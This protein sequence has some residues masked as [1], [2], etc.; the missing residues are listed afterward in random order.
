MAAADPST[1]ISGAEARRVARNAT[2]IA[3]AR[4][5]SNGALFAWQLALGR[6]LGVF[7][8]GVYGTVGAL[9]AVGVP[10]ASFSMGMIVI[11]DVARD[12]DR[13]GRYLS[14]TLLL[15]TSLALLA[16]LGMNAAALALGYSDTIRVFV[17]LAGISLFIDLTGNMCF[18]QLIARE[19]MIVTSAVDVGHIILRIA[20][21]GLL[22]LAGF[23]LLGVYAAT[24]F[25]GIVR[26]ATLWTALH[27]TGAR[28]AFP[29]DRDVAKLLLLNSAPLAMSA[30]LSLAYQHADKLMTTSLIGE[31]GTGYLT[32][33]FVV[34]YGVIEL[35]STTILI[36]TYPLMS[37]VYDS[38]GGDD[39]FGF[40]VGKLAFFTLIVSLPLSLTL[41]IFATDITVPL[42]GADFRP[43][44]DV[45]R[46]LIWYALVTMVANVFAQGFMVQNQQRRL[47]AIRATGLGLN[48]ILN[49]LLITRI[50][51]IG[52]AV[53]SV[54][55]ECLVLGLMLANFRAAGWD[56]RV[57]LPR[58]ARVAALG[59]VVGLA[60]LLLNPVHW[61]LGMVAGLALYAVGI[62]LFGT[63]AA[64]DWDLLY[65]LTA[66]MPGGSLILRFW[67]RD[68]KLNW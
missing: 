59:L 55:A 68:V 66:A 23:G 11:R 61:I 25:S 7:D 33:A 31:T 38:V 20:L 24:I 67:R 54:L 39:L 26:S 19:R 12:P 63:L 14:A 42:F 5:L 60:M 3:V 17:A 13:A 2:A 18:D 10:I 47:L 27:R 43:T 50:G 45:L 62:P 6:L 30:F 64:D 34:I 28:P 9:F 56:W 52:A 51:V 22:L 41:T 36:A 53:A 29:L 48:I 46:V 16:Y 35:L 57:L 58:L 44:A 40:I 37:R 1:R 4:I 49:L 15:Q 32:A 65:R 21:A 8:F